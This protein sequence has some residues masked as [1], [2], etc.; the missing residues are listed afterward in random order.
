[1]K[2][3]CAAQ[4]VHAC[5][6]KILSFDLAILFPFYPWNFKQQQ[7]NVPQED[8]SACWRGQ[9]SYPSALFGIKLFIIDLI[10]QRNYVSNQGWMCTM[11]WTISK[12]LNLE[13]KIVGFSENEKRIKS[14]YI[15]LR[16]PLGCGEFNR[17]Q[18]VSHVLIPSRYHVLNPRASAAFW[19]YH[20]ILQEVSLHHGCATRKSWNGE[21]NW[22]AECQCGKNTGTECKI[23][24]LSVFL[25][26]RQVVLVYVAQ[27]GKNNLCMS[28][29]RIFKGLTSKKL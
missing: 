6:C 26:N 2:N 17:C 15:G 12:S 7:H 10:Q 21:H 27:Y 1:M 24:L 20:P 16:S 5:Q 9:I 8:W 23:V 11:N 13:G 29:S 28:N 14:V 4:S 19:Y 18:E 3:P 25:A 22:S